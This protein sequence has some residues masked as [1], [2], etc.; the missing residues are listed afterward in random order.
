MTLPEL[1]AALEAPEGPSRDLDAEIALLE[2][3]EDVNK[4]ACVV[5]A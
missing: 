2:R 1:I 3:R 4:K 5:G